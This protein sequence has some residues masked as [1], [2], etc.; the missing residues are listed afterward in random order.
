[1]EEWAFPDRVN[2]SQF[3]G[4]IY[5]YHQQIFHDW[6]I[7]WNN[8][9]RIIDKNSD[10]SPRFQSFSSGWIVATLQGTRKKIARLCDSLPRHPLKPLSLIVV[11]LLLDVLW[12]A[13][14][15]LVIFSRVDW[16]ISNDGGKFQKDLERI[17]D[18][19]TIF[20]YFAIKTF[21]ERCSENQCGRFL[22][23]S[24]KFGKLKLSL[25]PYSSISSKS[26]H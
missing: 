14:L 16:F 19:H 21:Q 26:V 24:W 2:C 11:L 5:G 7:S 3:Q 18:F 12:P 22:S 10:F 6:S 17:G 20:C 4:N 1:M 13:N 8:Y 25:T 9:E 23:T 15:T